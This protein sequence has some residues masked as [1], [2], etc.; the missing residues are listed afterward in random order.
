MK[1]IA[2]IG[3]DLEAIARIKAAL[4]NRPD[5]EFVDEK[6]VHDLKLSIENGRVRVG[7]TEY[8]PE[9][10]DALRQQLEEE[11]KRVR[12]ISLMLGTPCSHSDQLSE[13]CA[14]A[15]DWYDDEVAYNVSLAQM[16]RRQDAHKATVK[17]QHVRPVKKAKP[18][19]N[20]T[21]GRR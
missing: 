11:D 20:S 10:F 13:M 1:Q 19:R 3:S 8:S 12:R 7:D 17:W 5:I 16:M 21:R 18:R 9:E 6:D 14:E 15:C 2:I 4:A